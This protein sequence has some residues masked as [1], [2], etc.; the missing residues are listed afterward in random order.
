MP[1]G[2]YSFVP[3]LMAVWFEWFARELWTA[4]TF[5]GRS[6]AGLHPGVDAARKQ[7]HG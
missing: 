3:V 6:P 2:E 7:P 5:G 1:L 4:K